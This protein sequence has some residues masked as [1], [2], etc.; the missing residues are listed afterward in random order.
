[1]RRRARAFLARWS[2]AFPG[3]PATGILSETDDAEAR[4]GEF[5]NDEPCPALDPD[6]GACDLYAARPM[7]C[8]TFGPPVRSGPEGALGVCELC[9]HGASDKQIASCEMKPDPDNLEETLIAD[10]E[11]ATGVHGNTIVAFCLRPEEDDAKE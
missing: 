11:A 10:V 8:R 3:D 7:T 5:A 6:T 1:V 9:Y 2:A 4:F